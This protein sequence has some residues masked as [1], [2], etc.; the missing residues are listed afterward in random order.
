MN[1]F[2]GP[3]PAMPALR[4]MA[5]LIEHMKQELQNVYGRQ[6]FTIAHCWSRDHEYI[7]GERKR[8]CV[9]VRV[10]NKVGQR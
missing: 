1:P 4:L 2:I 9:C 3:P 8:V 7:C 10:D 6:W 5:F